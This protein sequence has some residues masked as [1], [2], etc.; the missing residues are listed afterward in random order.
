MNII[1]ELYSGASCSVCHALRPK[2]LELVGKYKEVKAEVIKV[3]E[4]SEKAAKNFVFSLPVVL[5]K[6]EGKEWKRFAGSFSVV[7]IENSIVAILKR[8]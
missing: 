6:V 1:V 3:E 8:L 5:V 2:V 4:Q 7:E